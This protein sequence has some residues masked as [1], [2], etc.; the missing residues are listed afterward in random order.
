MRSR[1]ANMGKGTGNYA[2]NLGGVP[3][4]KLHIS[5]GVKRTHRRVHNGGIPAEYPFQTSIEVVVH[6]LSETSL[7]WFLNRIQP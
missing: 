4:S 1:G 5:N 3:V 2:N 6:P 7:T